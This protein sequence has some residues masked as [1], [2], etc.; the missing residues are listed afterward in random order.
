M[1]ASSGVNVTFAGS[2]KIAAATARQ[3][4]TSKPLQTF[5]SSML[6]KP[7][8]PWPTPQFSV[9][10]SL[11][12]FRVWARAG[13]L[14]ANSRA[15]NA[16]T[17]RM[18][19]RLLEPDIFI[20]R[21]VA[22]GSLSGGKFFSGSDVGK[23]TQVEA[24]PMCFRNGSLARREL[25]RHRHRPVCVPD[26]PDVRTTGITLATMAVP[27]RFATAKLSPASMRTAWPAAISRALSLI[28]S[29]QE[30]VAA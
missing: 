21:S 29:S 27:S 3:I 12:A 23:L 8:S 1:A 13:S 14:L 5:L 16:M 4:S 11:T 20:P 7:S 24:L 19:G 15:S 28:D 17:G 25:R 30:P 2:P 10:R 6:E 18:M 22:A 26:Q 9:P